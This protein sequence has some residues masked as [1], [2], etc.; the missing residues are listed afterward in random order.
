VNFNDLP[1][2][3][4]KHLAGPAGS[5][6]ALFFLKGT[7]RTYAGSFLGG[8]AMAHYFGRVVHETFPRMGLETSGFA[9]GLLGVI[10]VKKL[11]DTWEQFDAGT[12]LQEW[13]RKVLKLE[14][15]DKTP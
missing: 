4:G 9:V 5:A 13:L 6:V 12:L 7:W 15:K 2:D 1:P 11:F 14:P 8:W 3:M 10:V